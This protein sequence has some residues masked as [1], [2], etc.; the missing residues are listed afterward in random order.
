M[1]TRVS[2]RARWGW[3][4]H[5]LLWPVSLATFA[6]GIDTTVIGVAL[7]SIQRDLPESAWGSSFVVVG[8]TLTFGALMLSAE[9]MA[10]V[11]DRQRVF[12]CGAAGFA[13]AS[14]ACGLAP[15][16]PV[17]VC[18]RLVQGCA[19]AMRNS[20]GLA[21]LAQAFAGPRQRLIP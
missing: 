4:Q 10:D 6:I 14:L 3:R 18:A 20:A 16:V 11:Y 12:L 2:G 7:P 5:A 9:H 21:I 15:T 13:L 1:A 19:A 17:L 8:Y